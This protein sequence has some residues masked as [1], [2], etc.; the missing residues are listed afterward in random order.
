MIQVAFYN[1]KDLYQIFKRWQRDGLL[2]KPKML[3]VRSPSG[4]KGKS[5]NSRSKRR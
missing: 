4:L 3:E 2:P 5:I 1:T